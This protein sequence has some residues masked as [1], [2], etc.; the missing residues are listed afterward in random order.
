LWG[1]N[2]LT[3]SGYAQWRRLDRA[4]GHVPPPTFTNGWARGHREYNSKH[5]TDQ[6]VLII[7][8]AI[9]NTT[10]STFIAKK[11]EGHD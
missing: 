11:V 6:T 1:L 5:E 3:I 8:K 4:R 7:T 10:N 2:P 9:T